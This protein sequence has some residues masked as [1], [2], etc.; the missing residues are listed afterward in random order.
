MLRGRAQ[1]SIIMKVL[2]VVSR[3]SGQ[4]CTKLAGR[5]QALAIAMQA[6]ADINIISHSSSTLRYI[7]NTIALCLKWTT[8]FWIVSQCS[9]H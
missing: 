7:S 9:V 5:V 3:A 6:P 1:L 2:K 4:S 8:C